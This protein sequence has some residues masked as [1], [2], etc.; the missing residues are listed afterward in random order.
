[1]K[2]VNA[3]I[4]LIFTTLI[5][6]HGQ[7]LLG[8]KE[9]IKRRRWPIL[10]GMIM[11]FAVVFLNSTIIPVALPT[12][13][14]DLNLSPVGLQ[15]VVNSYLLVVAC[16]V[17]A[18]GRIAD[19]LGHRRVCC[20]GLAIFG[21]FSIMGGFSNNQTLLITSC[22]F[23]GLGGAILIPSAMSI[24]FETYHESERGSAI[25]ILVAVSSLFLSLGPFIGGLLTQ[26]LTWRYI[27]WVNLPVIMTGLVIIL[28]AVPRSPRLKES[29]DFVGFVTYLGTLVFLI[30]GLMQTR[31]LGWGS[32][33]VRMFFLLSAIFALFLIKALKASQY[34][35]FDL[36]LFCIKNF[37]GGNLIVFCIQ[38]IMMMTVFLSIFF[39]K[40][41]RLTPLEAGLLTLIST[42]PLMICAP[43]GGYLSD[44]F[45][46]K[47]SVLIGLI[48]SFL[49]CLWIG[50][51]IQKSTINLK[52]EISFLIPG[53]ICH[54]TGIALAMTPVGSA[55][56][57]GVDNKRKGIAS[58]TYSTVRNI[59][60]TFSVA[61]LGS[62]IGNITQVK[63]MSLLRGNPS[64]PK[65]QL[66]F[67]VPA[68]VDGKFAILQSFPGP[69]AEKI[70]KAYVV[71]SSE[72][73]FWANILCALVALI[74][75]F[76]CLYFFKSFKTKDLNIK[77]SPTTKQS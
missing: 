65:D 8:R 34:P 60:A 36:K 5:I 46:P 38:F 57:S 77:S 28:L 42:L 59:S 58:G 13:Q 22:S 69:V 6:L 72:A 33:Y 10:L 25:G 50:F 18:G 20:W 26:Y 74:G 73:V 40:T 32:A 66:D 9:V 52:Q 1:M 23:Q 64:I 49:G 62:F 21:L 54:G 75:F 70:Q 76:L 3:N 14:R 15:W 2:K 11:C 53:L 43:L 48:F 56:L 47:W 55:T 68:L 17:L 35:F 67:L 63:L 61:V 4:E 7:S 27:F 30:L 24:I 45:G 19:I 37:L 16:F 39:Q 29:F 12:I 44:R 31:E 51:H 71:A 41:C